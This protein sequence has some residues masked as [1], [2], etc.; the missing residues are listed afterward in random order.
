MSRKSDRRH[1]LCLIFA[2]DFHKDDEFSPEA[3]FEYYLECFSDDVLGCGVSEKDYV[4][5]VYSG[6]FERLESMDEHI[7]QAAESWDIGRI[8]KLDLAAMRLAVYEMLYMEEI[9]ASVAI[10]E[11]V[12][13]VKDFSDDNAHKF[14]NGVLEKIR[15]EAM[16][17]DGN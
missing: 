14:V 1:L 10:N 9:T 6:V 5:T 15:R 12:E 8:S 7:A 17:A 2:R 4:L 16:V 13:L 11:A 3:D